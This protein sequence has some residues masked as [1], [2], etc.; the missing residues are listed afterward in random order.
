MAKRGE[1]IYKRKDGRWEARIIKGYN[2]QG[3]ATYEYFYGKTYKDV[4]NKIFMSLSFVDNI[5]VAQEQSDALYFETLLDKWLSN[6]KIRLKES[7]YVKYSNLINTH[8][9]PSLGKYLLSDIT[10]EVLNKFIASK[11][12]KGKCETFK[13]LSEKTIKDIISVIQSALRY[14]KDESLLGDFSINISLPK[15]SQREYGCCLTKNRVR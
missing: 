1:N 8:I 7:S 15:L 2:K 10:S 12:G 4:K 3:R 5:T 13:R 11:L 6:S 9:N 14:A